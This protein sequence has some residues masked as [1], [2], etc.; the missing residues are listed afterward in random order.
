MH[1]N[2]MEKQDTLIDRKGEILRT[3]KDA[4]I[5]HLRY[6]QAAHG[7]VTANYFRWHGDDRATNRLEREYMQQFLEM[8]D[9][10]AQ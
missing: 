2:M 9:T 3:F 10:L 4:Q 6:T 1:E 7:I 8:S 5:K